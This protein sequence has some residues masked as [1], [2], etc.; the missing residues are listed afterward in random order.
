MKMWRSSHRP[1]SNYIYF[2]SCIRQRGPPPLLMERVFTV[3]SWLLG[4]LL[5]AI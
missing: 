1:F 4:S 2:V 3:R 5:G